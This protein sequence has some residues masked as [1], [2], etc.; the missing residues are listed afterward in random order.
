[1]ADMVVYDD[2][3]SFWSATQALYTADP[4]RHT[5]VLTAITRRL[6]HPKPDT[7][8]EILVTAQENGRLVGAAIQMPPYPLIVGAIPLRLIDDFVA[9]LHQL[10]PDLGGVN[11]DRTTA[12]AFAAAWSKRTGCTVTEDMAM[13]LHRLTT[14][15]VP[16]V[17]GE[18]RL[19]T[20]SDVEMLGD[21]HHDFV[22]EAMSHTPETD[23]E[24]G[25]RREITQG[26]AHAIWHVG[27]IPV[28]WAAASPPVHNMSRIGPVYTPPVLR[29]N[30]Y[31]AAVTAAV[32]TWARESGAD[33]VLLYTDLANPT[34]NALYQRIGFVPVF[35]ATELSLTPASRTL[36]H[37]ESY[38][39]TP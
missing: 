36:R 21:W 29:N 2:L 18:M 34:S 39:Q 28:S 30:G 20:D 15:V 1:M 3:A 38:A 9:T 5:V 7:E 27:C 35:D 12:E 11:G 37:P 14:L 4:V 13:S 24:A 31:A 33:E 6:T 32:A 17:R 8:P 25:I 22:T 16:E 19:A 26:H 10:V 23:V